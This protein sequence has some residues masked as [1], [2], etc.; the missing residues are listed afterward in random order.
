[1]SLAFKKKQ[2]SF[3]SSTAF[4]A[5]DRRGDRLIAGSKDQ[6]LQLWDVAMNCCHHVFKQPAVVSA[7][8]FSPDGKYL[9]CGCFNEKIA[10]Y[11][12]K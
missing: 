10:V 11:D 7:V 12:P 5:F 6:T 2:K 3:V 4:M 1:M 9:V 8:T